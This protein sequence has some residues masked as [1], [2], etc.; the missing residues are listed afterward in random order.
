MGVS[1]LQSFISC[2]TAIQHLIFQPVLSLSPTLMGSIHL[3][4]TVVFYWSPVHAVITTVIATVKAELQKILLNQ[5]Q[6]HNTLITKA[7]LFY[8]LCV[9][10]K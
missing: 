8:E 9:T 7:V 10:I 2:Y 3:L 6:T 5:W 4:Y 1:L